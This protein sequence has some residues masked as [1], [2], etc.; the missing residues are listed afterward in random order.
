ME[1]SILHIFVDHTNY[2]GIL[3]FSITREFHNLC[4][5]MRM[6]QITMQD[7][8]TIEVFRK[9]LESD[10]NNPNLMDIIPTRKVLKEVFHLINAETTVDYI[11]SLPLSTSDKFKVEI[12]ANLT[13][14]LERNQ[15]RRVYNFFNSFV[16]NF[17]LLDSVFKL[18]INMTEVSKTQETPVV[19][20][21]VIQSN[22]ETSNNSIKFKMPNSLIPNLKTESS[23]KEESPDLA[24][25]SEIEYILDTYCLNNTF[26]SF[27]IHHIFNHLR[28]LIN[29]VVLSKDGEEKFEI[30]IPILFD[31]F[32][33]SLN[34]DYVLSVFRNT[35]LETEENVISFN[36]KKILENIVVDI[37]KPQDSE[38]NLSIMLLLFI[39]YCYQYRTITSK[40]PE[41]DFESYFR[42]ELQES[43]INFFVKNNGM[44]DVFSVKIL[45]SVKDDDN[46]LINTISSKYKHL[47]PVS[48][49][50]FL[51]IVVSEYKKKKEFKVEDFQISSTK[52]IDIDLLMN[53]N[54]MIE[55][56]KKQELDSIDTSIYSNRSTGSTLLNFDQKIITKAYNHFKEY[57]ENPTTVSSLL[58]LKVLPVPKQVIN[59]FDFFS[60]NFQKL[61]TNTTNNTLDYYRI[62]VD[63]LP[64]PKSYGHQTYLYLI[65]NLIIPY[66]YDNF[67]TTK[68]IDSFL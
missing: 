34:Y 1:L 35:F 58:A 6:Y 47:I 57:V 26:K 56:I 4:I 48:E 42:P 40:Y 45:E 65:Y 20:T 49:M 41:F 64:A 25:K 37:N 33:Y 38:T 7:S 46:D 44:S 60:R 9:N 16:K 51:D 23:K 54:S 39:F 63:N 14:V 55:K 19:Q 18:Y 11:E 2:K 30:S 66:H 62:L 27:V 28:Y 67:K 10:P 53:S 5:D 36:Q 22:K 31:Q 68:F 32:Y 12:G 3:R 13:C 59:L 61:F 43:G 15:L 8:K 21:Q 17:A 50:D 52:I 24:P 29:A